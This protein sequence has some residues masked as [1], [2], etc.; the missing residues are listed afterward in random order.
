MMRY[1]VVDKVKKT[2]STLVGAIEVFVPTTCSLQN[3]ML[4]RSFDK[5]VCIYRCVCNAISS[6]AKIDKSLNFRS[7]FSR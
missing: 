5:R 1:G 4:G 3:L 7:H 2:R 6:D